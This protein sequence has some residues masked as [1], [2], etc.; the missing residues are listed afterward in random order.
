MGKLVLLLSIVVAGLGAAIVWLGL[1]LN[2]TQHELAA[3]RSSSRSD[4][5]AVLMSGTASASRSYVIPAM[6]STSTGSTPRAV[7]LPISGPEQQARSRDLLA[8]YH[9]PVDREELFKD[10]M[11]LF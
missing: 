2:A 8:K 6:G 5:S 10:R 3:A 7:S 9:D 11:G 1:R 4:P